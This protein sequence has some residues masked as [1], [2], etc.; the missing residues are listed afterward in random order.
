MNAGSD[1]HSD[2]AAAQ[3]PGIDARV[4][5]GFPGNLQHQPLLGVEGRGLLW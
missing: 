5:H 4:L 1:E 2:P 3:G